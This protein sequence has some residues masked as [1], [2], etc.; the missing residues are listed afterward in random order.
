[1]FN[2][3]DQINAENQR[4][5]IRVCDICKSIDELCDVFAFGSRTT[6]KYRADSDI[7]VVVLTT[8]E[9]FE[10]I[11]QVFNST[12]VEGLRVDLKSVMFTKTIEIK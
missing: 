7:D 4:L 9:K 12:F 6:N 11:K 2:S 10:H 8:K 3:F 1:M 5:F